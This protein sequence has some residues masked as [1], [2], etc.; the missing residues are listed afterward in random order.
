[1]VGTC[2]ALE[3]QLR[4]HDVV[5]LDRRGVGEETSYGNAGAIQREAVEPY[6]MPRDW[7]SLLSIALRRGL[8]VDYQFTGLLSAWPRLFRYWRESAPDRH[9]PTARE[10]ASLI[11][12]STREHG[13]LMDLAGRGTFCARPA[14][15]LSTGRQPP[16]MSLASRPDVCRRNMDCASA[17]SMG[18]HC[19]RSSR[20]FGRSWRVPCIG[21]TPGAW[22]TLA[23]SS[24]AMR[25]YSRRAAAD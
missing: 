20:P 8:D 2:T 24:S 6:A 12:H 11:A 5:L 19:V 18:P 22:R 4:G 17:F 9:R 25:R 7:R 3:L 15:V 13:R 21:R 16:W 14:C 1:M 23:R 10:Y